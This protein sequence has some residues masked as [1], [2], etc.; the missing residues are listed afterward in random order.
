[1]RGIVSST[2]PALIQSYTGDAGVAFGRNGFAVSIENTSLDSLANVLFAR[3]RHEASHHLL[4]RCLAFLH[5]RI[6]E[7]TGSI[8]FHKMHH[9]LYSTA[10][11]GTIGTKGLMQVSMALP[12]AIISSQNWLMRKQS[13][14]REAPLFVGISPTLS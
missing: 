2:Y 8:A 7:Y 1:M 10:S 4:E 11:Q 12:V 3:L 6:D 5:T 13:P 9:D 14:L